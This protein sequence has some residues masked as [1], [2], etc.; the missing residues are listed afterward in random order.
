MLKLLQSTS[1]KSVSLIWE[2]TPFILCNVLIIF[3]KYSWVPVSNNKRRR[4]NVSSL[5]SPLHTGAYASKLTTRGLHY[6]KPA[7]QVMATNPLRATEATVSWK[8]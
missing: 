4:E 1:A 3:I 2:S 7:M 6:A 5:Y 8:K